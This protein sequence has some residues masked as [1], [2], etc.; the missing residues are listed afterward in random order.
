M[1]WRSIAGFIHASLRPVLMKRAPALP[2][3]ARER[4]TRP[5]GVI[6]SPLLRFRRHQASGYYYRTRYHSP[7]CCVGMFGSYHQ[8]SDASSGREHTS[9]DRRTRLLPG[10]FVAERRNCTCLHLRRDPED[11]RS[12]A[13]GDLNWLGVVK[14]TTSRPEV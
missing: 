14:S 5:A 13:T 9:S 6:P 11:D 10:S 3:Q 2:K 1:R 7:Q 12:R 4:T 8:K